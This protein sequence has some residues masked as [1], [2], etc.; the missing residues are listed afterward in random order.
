MKK[1]WFLAAGFIIGT[2]LRSSADAAKVEES[3]P[4]A[5][6]VAVSSSPAVAAPVTAPAPPVAPR[7]TGLNEI[8]GKLE[9]KGDDPKT[10]RLTVDGGYNVEFTYD[11]KTSIINGGNPVS[12]DDLNYGDELIVRYSGM[13]LNAVEID[14]VSKAPRPQ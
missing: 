4:D 14:R 12:I 8:R 3:T 10:L 13:E 11:S 9:S 7:I 1:I 6:K 5:G 2:P